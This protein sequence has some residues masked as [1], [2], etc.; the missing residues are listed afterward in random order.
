[1]ANDCQV[2]SYLQKQ[3][4]LASMIIS[5]PFGYTTIGHIGLVKKN[6]NGEKRQCD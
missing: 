1:M 5:R 4:A 2:A 3:L 6:E